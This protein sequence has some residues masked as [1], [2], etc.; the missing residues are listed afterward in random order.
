MIVH[1][2]PNNWSCL[3]TA[4]AM[5]IG[6]PTDRII[7][8]IGHDGSDELYHAK[9]VKAGFHEQECIE[10]LQKFGYACTPIEIVPCI[11]PNTDLSDY[12]LVYFG[13]GLTSNVA[14]L[15][16][17]LEDSHG[18][19][20]GIYTKNDKVT[21]HAVAWDG[22]MIYDPNFGGRIY[23]FDDSSKHGFT[24]RCYWKVQHVNVHG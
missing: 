8:E 10:V 5:A 13:D 23:T 16:R 11:S 21:G 20:T 22:T 14:R 18:V 9:G 19:L 7:Q 17:H 3:P 12:R 6:W 4:F 24:P 2:N 1:P 15:K